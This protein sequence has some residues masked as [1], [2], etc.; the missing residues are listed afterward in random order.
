MWKGGSGCRGQQTDTP[1]RQQRR[2]ERRRRVK[3]ERMCGLISE[4]TQLPARCACTPASLPQSSCSHSVCLSVLGLYSL[5]ST[6]W[7]F[8][9]LCILPAGEP[10]L[11]PSFP[12]AALAHLSCPHPHFFFEKSRNLLLKQDICG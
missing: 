10:L 1:A 3:P 7:P 5:T 11:P 6:P 12:T 9:R 2:C 4:A 8:V